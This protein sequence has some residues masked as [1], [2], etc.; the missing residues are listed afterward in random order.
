MQTPKSATAFLRWFCRKD[1]LE[2]IEGDLV[3]VYEKEVEESPRKA[4][5]KFAWSVLKYIR[6][7]FVKNLSLT[8]FNNPIMFQHYLKIG[9]RTLLKNKTYSFIN[10]IGLTVGIACCLS[11]FV[12]VNYESGFDNFHPH[13]NETFR[14]VQQTTYPDQTL[15]WNTTAFPLAEALRNDFQDLSLVTQTAGPLNRL[16]VVENQGN[17]NVQFESDYVL[18]VD[19]QYPEVFEL[20]WIEGDKTTAFQHPHSVVL[21][22]SIAR[23]CF[24]NTM[25]TESILGK[26]ILLAGKDPLLVTG[27]VK[28]V[29]GNTNLRYEMLVPYE[30]FKLNNPYYSTNWSGNYSGTT[31]VV[32]PE[33]KSSAAIES[34]I[35]SW[36]KKYLNQDD[37]LRISYK[38]QPLKSIHT[39]SLYGSSP[40]GYT[41]SATILQTATFVGIFILLIAVANFINLVTANSVARSKE[42]GI[43]KIIGSTKTDLFKQFIIENSLLV[44]ISILLGSA[45][46]MIMLSQGNTILSSLNLHLQ[47]GWTDAGLILLLGGLI[48]ILGTF[49]PA[50]AFSATKPLQIIS[51]S[52]VISR[53]KGFSVRK[54]LMVFQFVIVQL[55]I[56]GAIVVAAQMDLIKRKDLG[57]NSEAVLMIPIPQSEKLQVL[58]NELI[59]NSEVEEITF[60]S[61]PPMA[62]NGLQLGT[63]YR[64]SEMANQQGIESE[65]K[66]GDVNYLNFYGLELIAG[67]NLTDN[68]ENFDEFIV[69]ER[70][71][72]SLNW[73]AEEAIGRK[74]V[75]NEGEG[76]IIGVTRD[77]HNNSLQNDISPCIII[78]WTYFLNLA[79]VRI[80]NVNPIVMQSIE[81]SWKETFPASIYKYEFIDDSIANEYFIETISFKGFTLFS[82][83]VI[84][85]GCMGLIGLM[86]FITSRRTKEVGIRKVLGA[87]VSEIILFFSK[88]FILLLLL[89]FIIALPFS[90]F[91]MQEWL[92]GF[93]YHVE[94]S[95]W[96]FLGGGLITFLIAGLSTGYLATK[97]ALANPIKSIKTE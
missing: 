18:F 33:N 9:G 87:S 39:E 21:T 15:Y 6:P 54:S 77:F 53:T 76:T 95:I 51:G 34:S 66:I 3:E 48:I 62:I 23:K 75:I 47:L 63:R 5:W 14:V 93:T 4:K 81:K 68:K 90:Y 28:D 45:L 32:V 10:I 52:M 40:G 42:V 64:S 72:K 67:R 46:S 24:G 83:I 8:A 80:K 97:A 79:F 41:M 36:K 70:L 69:N 56:I 43:R 60:G 13:S 19:A 82:F 20:F 86:T 29:P 7:G 84:V 57:F 49:Y 55:F 31:F 35:A 26:T 89:A 44:L 22:E 2:E 65:M 16:F 74:L 50:I 38:L 58:K 71:I 1:Y 96:M 73:T 25:S 85:I 12:F 27:L 17:K 91:F 88:E 94:M 30:F 61:G 59:G 78:N 11:L 37:D 92:K